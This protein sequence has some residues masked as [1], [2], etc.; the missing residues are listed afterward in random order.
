MESFNYYLEGPGGGGP[1]NQYTARIHNVPREH[2]LSCYQYNGLK[3]RTIQIQGSIFAQIIISP[4]PF[5][6]YTHPY[7]NTKQGQGSMAYLRTPCPNIYLSPIFCKGKKMLQQLQQR[8]SFE[9]VFSF[10]IVFFQERSSSMNLFVCVSRGGQNSELR[11]RKRGIAVGRKGNVSKT[12]QNTPF[13]Q[14]T[15]FSNTEMFWVGILFPLKMKNSLFC[16][17]NILSLITAS[18][19]M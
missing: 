7:I 19:E 8:I 16:V 12:M 9:I 18:T 14:Q 1:E 10:P 5:G 13:R 3:Q 17:F 6:K 2:I 4:P 11:G 15:I